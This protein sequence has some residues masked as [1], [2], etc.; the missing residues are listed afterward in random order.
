MKFRR[1]LSHTTKRRRAQVETDDSWALI[2]S[3]LLSFNKEN[4]SV[5]LARAFE[6]VSGQT[7][8]IPI[9]TVLHHEGCVT[10]TWQKNKIKRRQRHTRECNIQFCL[11][12]KLHKYACSPWSFFLSY[13]C[14]FWCRVVHWLGETEQ[15]VPRQVCFANSGHEAGRKWACNG[16]GGKHQWENCS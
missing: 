5:Y 12:L 16:R 4:I 15:N 14:A 6:I 8:P 10:S 13:V 9:V 3:V 7:A 2:N 1:K 11:P